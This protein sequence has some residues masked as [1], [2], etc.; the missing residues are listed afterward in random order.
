MERENDNVLGDAVI[1]SLI[2][3]FYE[4]LCGCFLAAVG[5]LGESGCR[6]F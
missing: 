5:L 6:M 1:I 3:K 2:V 4:W